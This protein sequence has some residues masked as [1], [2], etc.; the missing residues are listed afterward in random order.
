VEQAAAQRGFG[1]LLGSRLLNRPV[2]TAMFYLAIGV[3]CFVLLWL[4]SWLIMTVFHPTS[5]SL[6][7]SILRIVPLAFC[8][9]MVIAPVYALRILIAGSRSFFAYT[10]GLV[11]VQ[12]SK[13]QTVAWTEVS[14]LR[15][16][17]ATRGDDAGKRV[18]YDLV[19]VNGSP[20]SIP[21]VIVD[22]RDEFLDHVIA[23]LR[24]HGRPIN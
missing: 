18:H 24:Q 7:W 11:Y 6:L 16:V 23:A 21:I 4:S 2:L 3:A 10:N 15:S 1:T 5:Y 20:V 17:I 9:G 14:E 13:I 19:P 22:G 8:F 12:R